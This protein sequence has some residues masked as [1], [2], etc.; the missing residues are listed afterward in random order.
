MPGLKQII[1]AGLLAIALIAS[2]AAYT[3][4]KTPAEASG[5][6]E[7]I[8][9]AE[10]ATQSSTRATPT[11][12]T[13]GVASATAA[14]AT[15]GALAPA[16]SSTVLQIVQAVFM[17]SVDVDAAA[18]DPHSFPITSEYFLNSDWVS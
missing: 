13:P 8:P 7:A 12:S 3:V 15:S 11:Q 16:T 9:L 4:F 17:S 6:I 10:S 18:S 14:S 5:Q 2:V 1:V